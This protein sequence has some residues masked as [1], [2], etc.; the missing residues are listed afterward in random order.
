MT[1]H[2]LLEFMYNDLRVLDEDGVYDDFVSRVIDFNKSHIE[3]YD[4]ETFRYLF[5]DFLR[6]NIARRRKI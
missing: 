4:E 6:N 1:D 5:H 3:P 2:F